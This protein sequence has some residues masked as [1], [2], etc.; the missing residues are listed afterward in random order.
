MYLNQ[1][2]LNKL[3]ITPPVSRLLKFLSCCAVIQGDGQAVDLAL[4]GLLKTPQAQ[5]SRG[6][7]PKGAKKEKDRGI[8]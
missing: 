3:D 6:H 5:G 8:I 1:R 2:K 7:P 4:G